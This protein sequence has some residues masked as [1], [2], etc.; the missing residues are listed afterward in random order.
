MILNLLNINDIQICSG[1]KDNYCLVLL[2][3]FC[4][5]K[6]DYNLLIIELQ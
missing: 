3:P 1:R 4:N 5:I 6:P 2:Q